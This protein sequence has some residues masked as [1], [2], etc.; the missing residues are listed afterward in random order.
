MWFTVVSYSATMQPCYHA[1]IFKGHIYI[2]RI[3]QIQQFVILLAR[4]TGLIMGTEM[5]FKWHK[6]FM[7]IAILAYHANLNEYGILMSVC[8]CS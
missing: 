4:I 8:V 5:N 6:C 3:P 7:K 1:Q 2:S